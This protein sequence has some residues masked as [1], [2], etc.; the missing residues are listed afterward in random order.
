LI[1][2]NHRGASYSENLTFNDDGSYVI[3]QGTSKYGTVLSGTI[4]ISQG[5]HIFRNIKFTGSIQVTGGKVVFEDCIQTEA[6]TSITG[7][8]TVMITKCDCWG[9]IT[10]SPD[11][12]NVKLWCEDIL[13]VY[14]PAAGEASIEIPAALTTPEIVLR[15]VTAQG[16]VS[17]TGSHISETTGLE[18]NAMIR[19]II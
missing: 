8:A 13:N 9:N 16:G 15:R 4:V 19:P 3:I 2:I 10:I 1:V 12:T 17:D 5:T 11:L 18:I 14:A 7:T 6:E